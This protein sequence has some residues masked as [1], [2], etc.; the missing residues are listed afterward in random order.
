MQGAGE[1][2]IVASEPE[3]RRAPSVLR[4]LLL[5]LLLHALLVWWS[6][7]QLY[8][9]RSESPVFTPPIELTLKRSA[10]EQAATVPEQQPPP[11]P[12]VAEPVPPSPVPE[13]AAPQPP[14]TTS[15]LLSTP[16]DL[17]LPPLVDP[18]SKAGTDNG[19]TVMNAE[20]LERLQRAPRRTGVEAR[21]ERGASGDYQGGSWVEFI[22]T[23]DACFQ[24][25]R[26]NPLLSFDYDVWYRVSCPSDAR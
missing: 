11:A 22:R 13:Q 18:E 2:I 7:G 26:A 23:G 10:P 1:A 5:S 20:L 3:W 6:R 21:V 4:W 16:L 14:A 24:V 8:L 12:P 15:P 9:P 19:A 17:S 25:A